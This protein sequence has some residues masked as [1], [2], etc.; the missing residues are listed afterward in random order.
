M[1][2]TK[3]TEHKAREVRHPS[4]VRPYICGICGHESNQATNHRRHMYAHHGMRPDG[5]QATQEEIDRA[6]GWNRAGWDRPLPASTAALPSST[7]YHS[8]ST[9]V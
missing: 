8:R 7:C 4:A 2:R 3:N 5:S 6:R 9:S 1:A